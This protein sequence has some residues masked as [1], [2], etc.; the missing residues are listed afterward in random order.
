V[1]SYEVAHL[2]HQQVPVTLAKGQIIQLSGTP[3][4][5]NHI[6]YLPVGACGCL[7][8]RAPGTYI[9]GTSEEYS[10]ADVSNTS[11]VVAAIL[12]RINQVFLPA[13]DFVVEDMWSGFRPLSPDELPILGLAADPRIVI[14]TG[15]F[16]NGVLLA[17]ITGLI[18]QALIEG[19]APPINL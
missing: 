17:P 15:H 16:R 18:V 5:L 7:L 6:L 1:W 2:F 13:G 19:T 12:S 11:R 8:E 3:R 9:A 4:L 14:A 10:T